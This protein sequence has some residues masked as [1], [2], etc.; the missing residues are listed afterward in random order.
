MGPVDSPPVLVQAA[1]LFRYSCVKLEAQ[2]GVSPPGTLDSSE[3][4]TGP[5]KFTAARRGLYGVGSRAPRPVLGQE[6]VLSPPFASPQLKDTTVGYGG[7]GGRSVSTGVGGSLP[8]RR[9]R[10]GGSASSSGLLGGLDAVL[11]ACD[12]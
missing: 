8:C 3:S 9:T 5:I 12:S 11:E 6:N 1:G 4:R 7:S 2:V 10:L